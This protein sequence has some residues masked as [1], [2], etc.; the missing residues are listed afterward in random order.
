MEAVTAFAFA[1]AA[2]GLLRN[3]AAAVFV[4]CFCTAAAAAAA[5][6]ATTGKT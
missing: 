5:A 1:F 4:A 2:D 3:F 6:S